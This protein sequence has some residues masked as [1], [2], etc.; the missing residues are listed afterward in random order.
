MIRDIVIMAA[1]EGTRFSEGAAIPSKCLAPV[2]GNALLAR[3]MFQARSAFG[4]VRQNVIVGKNAKE[5]TDQIPQADNVRILR[6]EDSA[7][8][9]AF[10]LLRLRKHFAFPIL[11]LLGDEF[12][13]DPDFSELPG[14]GEARVSFFASATEDQ[15]RGNFA[16]LLDEQKRVLG[17]REKPAEPGSALCGC[18][19]LYL[20]ENGLTALAGATPSARTGRVELYESLNQLVGQ[21]KVRAVDLR[22]RAYVN[23]NTVEDWRRAQE[24]A[25]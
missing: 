11:V 25:T 17:I 18:G 20:T 8:G 19:P 24:L 15:V 1:G 21:E 12:F 23:V 2:G 10:S 9:L 22:A 14:P 6:I 5:V 4:N 3:L 16:I 7:E 13:L